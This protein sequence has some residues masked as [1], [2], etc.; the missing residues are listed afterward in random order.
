MKSS[1]LDM[2]VV[3][4][5]TPKANVTVETIDVFGCLEGP[6]LKVDATCDISELIFIREVFTK[7]NVIPHPTVN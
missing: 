6:I 7:T 5:V 2:I 1:N 3:M 4:S